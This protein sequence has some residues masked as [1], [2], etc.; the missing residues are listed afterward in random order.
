MKNF[1][2]QGFSVVL[3]EDEITKEALI[4]K[5]N[6]LYQDRNQYIDAMRNSGQQDSIRTIL[7]LIETAHTAKK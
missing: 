2:R 3:E 1:E 7:Q 5:V 4:D 6:A